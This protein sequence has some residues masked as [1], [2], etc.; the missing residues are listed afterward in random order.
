MAVSGFERAL[1]AVARMAAD[2]AGLVILFMM[3]VGVVD[4]ASRY[5]M[6][7]PLSSSFE[8]VQF[9]MVL[10][11]FGGLASC[12]Y[13][14]GHVTINVLDGLLNRP[15]ARWIKALVHAMGSVVFVTIAWRSEQAALDYFNSGETSNML[16]APLYPFVAAVAFGSGMFGMV[17][18]L[19]VLK[20]LRREDGAST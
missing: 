2:L 5:L 20:S 18:T 6:N 8:L 11:V 13:V 7:A 3:F 16:S 15:N 12:G 10:V 9:S 1:A 19:Q 17:L 14:G 4:I